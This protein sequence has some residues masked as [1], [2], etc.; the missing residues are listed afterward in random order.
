MANALPDINAET[1]PFAF[2]QSLLDEAAFL[3]RVPPEQRGP[4]RD[5]FHAA[6]QRALPSCDPARA[7]QLIAPI[8]AARQAV[9][10]D[11][12]LD[13]IEPSE[14]PYHQQHPLR[15]LMRAAQACR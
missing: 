7:E 10:Y 13:Q 12:F 15:W 2:V 4:L 14:H 5:H 3:E 11:K 8:A 6:W 1:Y 9:I